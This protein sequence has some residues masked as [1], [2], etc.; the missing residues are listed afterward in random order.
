MA[1]T[2]KSGPAYFFQGFSIISDKAIRPYVLI[3]IFVNIVLLILLWG[4]MI[5]EMDHWL[6]KL[7]QIIPAWLLWLNFLIWPLFILMLFVITAYCFS[8]LANWIAS[9]FL[10]LLSERVQLLLNGDPV[11]EISWGQ[12]IV[13]LPSIIGRQLRLV[14]YYIPR[15]ILLVIIMF[16]PGLN[17]ISGLLWFCFGAWMLSI[18]YLD[19]PLDNNQKSYRELMRFAKKHRW[20]SFTFGVCAMVGT[21]IPVVNLFVI[22]AAVAGATALYVDTK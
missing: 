19:Y 7:D 3:P 4:W 12:I 6:A 2:P 1:H 17:T 16:I 20:D 14:L 5:H 11:P 22:P 10:G 8:L 18:Q 21:M 13:E 9:P 15:A